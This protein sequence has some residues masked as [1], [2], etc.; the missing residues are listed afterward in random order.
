MYLESLS[1]ILLIDLKSGFLL[2]ID[3]SRLL[4]FMISK[5]VPNLQINQIS[6]KAGLFSIWR[7]SSTVLLSTYDIIITSSNF[8]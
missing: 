4:T 5:N 6:V 1:D 8:F 7:A 3:S 2:I